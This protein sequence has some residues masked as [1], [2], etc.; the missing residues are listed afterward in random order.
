[1]QNL[2]TAKPIVKLDNE[3]IS[4]YQIAWIFPKHP[5]VVQSDLFESLEI[6][7]LFYI[8]LLQYETHNFLPNQYQNP[9]KPVVKFD[10]NKKLYVNC[11]LSSK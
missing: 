1:M 7:L 2:Q 4:P 10:K 3:N 6:Y 9:Q 11:I 5:F 8:S